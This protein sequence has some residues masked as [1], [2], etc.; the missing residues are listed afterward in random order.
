MNFYFPYFGPLIAKTSLTEQQI[1]N[2]KK[3]C[4]KKVN[5]RKQLAGHIKDE[6]L[7]DYETY[8]TIIQPQLETFKNAYKMFYNKE[9]QS[10][11]TISAWVNYMKAGDFNPPH[12]HF[13]CRFSSVLFL[14]VPEAIKK[15][16]DKFQG[17][18][19]GPGSLEFSYGQPSKDFIDVFSVFPKV[20]DMY[21]FPSTTL[22]SVYPFK[23][24]NVTRIS[25]AAN[26]N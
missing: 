11:K 12:I 15:E 13:E 22:H 18:S 2:I 7:M 5:H 26:Y 25:V 17:T 19:R 3:L 10:I 14:Q 1:K 23:S 16:C 4:N 24:K 8:D 20:G 9:L 21:I 6:Y